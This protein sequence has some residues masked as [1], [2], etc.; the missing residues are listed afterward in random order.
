MTTATLDWYGC[1]T[2]RL[3]TAEG[4]T[5]ML[6]AYLDRVPTAAQSGVGVAEVGAELGPQD[7][8]LVGHAHFDHLYGAERL[9]ATGARIVGS[10]ESVRV[11]AAW[12]V[13]EEQLV[14][15]SGGE[16]VRLDAATTVRVLPGLH[17]CV[18]SRVPFPDADQVCLGEAGG[19]WQ[20]HQEQLRAMFAGL[21]DLGPEV[22]AHLQAASQGERGDG[23]ALVYVVETSEGSLLVQDTA[24]AWS[25][26]LASE[27]PDVAILAAAGRANRDGEPVQGTLAGFV[28]EEAGWLRPQRLV[29]SHHDAWLPGFAGAVDVGPIREAVAAAAPDTEF[30][31]LEYASGFRLFDG[32]APRS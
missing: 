16:R 13:P 24:G 3:R 19:T 9:A 12:G 2:F 8:I 20:E 1:A 26:L 25:G 23:G 18:W 4:L 10:Y 11:M 15:V 31:E 28:A 30:C 5:V 22:A 6:D 14:P 32:C 21:P 29:L 17:S 7:W 27:S